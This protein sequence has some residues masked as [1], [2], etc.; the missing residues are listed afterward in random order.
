MSVKEFNFLN[1]GSFLKSKTDKSAGSDQ[2]EFKK[3]NSN[4]TASEVNVK[5]RI[6]ILNKIQDGSFTRNIA[7]EA[8]EPKAPKAP[9]TEKIEL[10]PLEVSKKELNK[11][12]VNWDT[13]DTEF[14][15][16][17]LGMIL[18]W[19]KAYGYTF[20]RVLLSAHGKLQFVYA[21]KDQKNKFR[22]ISDINSIVT[23][24]VEAPEA[25]AKEEKAKVEA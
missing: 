22:D 4:A 20:Q 9:K 10:T 3:Y 11:A 2:I 13:E 8:K 6:A 1:F 17:S 7:G 23:V 19:C 16:T 24:K 12:L 5:G 14:A 21:D 25:E 15:R 18:A